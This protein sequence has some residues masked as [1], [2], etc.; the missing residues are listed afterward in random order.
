MKALQKII[1]AVALVFASTVGTFAQ[2][3]GPGPKGQAMGMQGMFIQKLNLTQDQLDKIAKL[4][5]EM[6]KKMVDLRAQLQKNRLAIKEEMLKDKIDEAKI[7][8]IV[9]ENSDIQAKMKMLRVENRFKIYNLLDDSQ[10]K[11]AKQMWETMPFGKRG[12]YFHRGGR[13]FHGRGFPHR[14]MLQ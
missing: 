12:K 7:K 14:G 1:L 11:I 3:V 10:K 5:T 6:Q 2:P 8:S 4:R 9:K 13:R